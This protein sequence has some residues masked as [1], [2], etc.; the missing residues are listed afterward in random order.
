MIDRKR[1]EQESAEAIS[2]LKKYQYLIAIEYFISCQI[3]SLYTIFPANFD[4]NILIYTQVKDK[5]IQITGSPSCQN[6]FPSCLCLFFAT[7][8]GVWFA[9]TLM[10]ILC[11]IRCHYYLNAQFCHNNCCLTPKQ[12]SDLQKPCDNF[13]ILYTYL[14]LLYFATYNNLLHEGKI[15]SLLPFSYEQVLARSNLPTLELRFRQ[16]ILKIALFKI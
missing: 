6:Q 11:E 3:E 13:L 2:G 10:V 7:R 5:W 12:Q 14:T 1:K 8:R 16:Q 15:K 4:I 9:L